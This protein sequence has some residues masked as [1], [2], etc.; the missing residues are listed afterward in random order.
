MSES[1]TDIAQNLWYLTSTAGEIIEVVIKRKEGEKMLSEPAL[2][3]AE[4]DEK[5][6]TLKFPEADGRSS[7]PIVE[8]NQKGYIRMETFQIKEH[9]KRLVKLVPSYLKER[10][11]F[12]KAANETLAEKSEKELKK[13]LAH[14]K[15]MPRKELIKRASEISDLER[16]NS[17]FSDSENFKD[18]E[19]F[20]VGLL[21]PTTDLLKKV[22][23][24]ALEQN[25]ESNKDLLL[26]KSLL[27]ETI[28]NIAR[29]NEKN[30]VNSE[31]FLAAFQ[32]ELLVAKKQQNEAVE[33]SVSMPNELP[34]KM[35]MPVNEFYSHLDEAVLNR[36]S[37]E[38]MKDFPHEYYFGTPGVEVFEAIRFK[39]FCADLQTNF[40][41]F[42]CDKV[43]GY[44]LKIEKEVKTA[45]E[46]STYEA[47]QN[48]VILKKLA[49]NTYE[50]PD[51]AVANISLQISSEREFINELQSIVNKASANTASESIEKIPLHTPEINEKIPPSIDIP[52]PASMPANTAES[53]VT[54]SQKSFISLENIPSKELIKELK[55]RKIQQ[56]NAASS[57]DLK[58]P[59]EL[60]KTAEK[61][62]PVYETCDFEMEM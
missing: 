54:D 5:N 18:T 29:E 57:D 21:L 28:K 44:S 8:L 42:S 39:R 55:I 47:L 48:A 23:L 53:P 10:G 13:E 51:R 4:I 20:P 46:K 24:N 36:F 61:E 49:E 15:F 59:K 19:K 37:E 43:D 3:R 38:K 12:P 27:L 22:R 60:P 32:R 2:K 58:P 6:D 35:I 16:I 50:S 14:F 34:K 7:I 41:N 40:N 45:P 26:T 62:P 9:L 30:P 31:A 17:F 52:S 1:K 56:E 11:M 25:P 33:I